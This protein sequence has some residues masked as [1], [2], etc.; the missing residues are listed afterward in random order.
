MN[1]TLLYIN[2]DGLVTLQNGDS[3]IKEPI[4]GP[5]IKRMLLDCSNKKI[6]QASFTENKRDF[7]MDGL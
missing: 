1:R 4:G 6:L 7:N 5:T 2:R 3:K